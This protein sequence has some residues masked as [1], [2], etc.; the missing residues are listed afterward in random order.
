MNLCL[1]TYF[2]VFFR[3]LPTIFSIKILLSSVRLITRH[4]TLSC[5]IMSEMFVFT[6]LTVHNWCVGRLT[7][8]LCWPCV[9]QYCWI[10]LILLIV[11]LYILLIYLCRQL[12]SAKQNTYISSFPIFIPLLFFLELWHRLGSPMW[13]RSDDSRHLT[14]LLNINE[15]LLK[16]HHVSM[17]AVDFLKYIFYLF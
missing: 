1:F 6:L 7:I 13:K 9:Q 17:F 10:N 5:A 3:I 14:L 11:Y 16:L 2:Q 8:F 15:M 12:Q 4:F